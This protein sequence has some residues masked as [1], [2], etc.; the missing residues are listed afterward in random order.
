MKILLTLLFLSFSAGADEETDKAREA[1]LE[2]FRKYTEERR[3]ETAEKVQEQERRNA[4]GLWMWALF[5]DYVEKGREISDEE[6][7]RIWEIYERADEE[8]TNENP[9]GEK[10]YAFSLITEFEDISKWDKEF[11]SIAMNE[12]P[13]YISTAINL[14]LSKLDRGTEREKII[15]SNKTEIMEHLANFAAANKEKIGNRRDAEKVNEFAKKYAGRPI[16]EE[17]SR[18]KKRVFE[19]NQRVTVPT[20]GESPSLNSIQDDEDT[21]GKYGIFWFA[22]ATAIILSVVLLVRKKAK[23]KV[24]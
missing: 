4:D 17:E 11:D 3:L 13:R 6:M 18:K 15:L 5:A 19:G 22:G 2:R 20:G 10:L 1:S 14:Y 8:R 12:D 7:A 21:G 24:S 9:V 23:L 16:P